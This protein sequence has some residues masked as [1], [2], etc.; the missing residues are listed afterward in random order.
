MRPKLP[1]FS[2]LPPI[3]VRLCQTVRRHVVKLGKLGMLPTAGRQR[4]VIL[5]ISD[6]LGNNTKPTFSHFTH[7]PYLSHCKTNPTLP[8]L[9]TLPA[10]IW[11][12]V[13]GTSKNQFLP[14]DLVPK[15]TQSVLCAPC[16]THGVLCGSIRTILTAR[17]TKMVQRT[18]RI[19]F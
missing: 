2:I 16:V 14:F 19:Y 7:T 17:G 5:H 8:I 4:L 6:F 1:S 12:L 11:C 3:F 10:P 18:Q 15:R 9:C 13:K